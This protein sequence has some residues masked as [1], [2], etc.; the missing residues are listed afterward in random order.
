PSFLVYYIIGYYWQ[1]SKYA[2]GPRPHP[3]VGNLRHLSCDKIHLEFQ[4]FSLKYGQIFTVFLPVLIVVITNYEGVRETY[5]SKGE[6]LAGR[7][8]IATDDVLGYSHNAGAINSN[9]QSWLEYRRLTITI[10]RDFGIGKSLIEQQIRLSIT[11]FLRHLVRIEN[12][13][14]VYLRWPIQLAEIALSNLLVR[15]SSSSF[16]FLQEV[17]MMKEYAKKVH[18]P[19]I[20]KMTSFIEKNT[21]KAMETLDEEGEDTYLVHAYSRKIGSSPHLTENRGSCNLCLDVSAAG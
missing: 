4:E 15:F 17:P 16:K 2:R 20:G 12:K 10:L 13:S 3:I 21:E 18:G 6:S 11:E 5:I 19:K 7:P 8:F 9:G 14:S 1:V